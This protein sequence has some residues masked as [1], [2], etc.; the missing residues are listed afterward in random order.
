MFIIC[1]GQLRMILAQ[2]KVKLKSF[3][4]AQTKITMHF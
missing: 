4:V 2:G 3:T 1:S